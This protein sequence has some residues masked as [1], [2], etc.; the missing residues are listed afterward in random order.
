[1]AWVRWVGQREFDIG[2]SGV[3]SM[4]SKF[5]LTVVWHALI[6]IMLDVSASL[7]WAEGVELNDDQ[8]FTRLTAPLEGEAGRHPDFS[9]RAEVIIERF[10]QLWTDEEF[11]VLLHELSDDTLMLRLRAAETA[12]FSGQEPWMLERARTALEV[13]L[14]RDLATSAHIRRLFDAY[15]AA[16]DF[17]AARMLSESHPDAG[18]PELPEIVPLPEDQGD[19]H[20]IVWHVHDD[21]PRLKGEAINL[22]DIRLLV[23]TSPGCG[24]SHQAAHALGQD[25]II[26]PLM[27]AHALWITARTKSHSFH[28]LLEWN[29]R[30]PGL[31]TVVVD[32]QE[33]WPVSSFHVYPRFFF[34]TG[35]QVEESQG[36]RGGA[37]GLQSIA[38]QFIRLGLLDAGNLTDDAF[39]YADD[40]AASGSCAERAPALAQANEGA[41]IKTSDELDTHLAKLEAGLDSP[42]GKLSEEARRRLVHSISWTSRG[43]AGFRHDDLAALPEPEGFYQIVSLFGKQYFYAGSFYPVELLTDEEADLRDR[44]NCAGDYVP[45]FQSEKDL[46]DQ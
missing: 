11:G 37:E 43:V 17:G 27:R 41:L 9:E 19:P 30:Y 6:L 23:V 14:A 42:F 46:T 35:D 31:E 20:W 29:Q 10:R 36:W 34:M 16:W 3:F 44:I 5:N 15:Q 24:F 12:L 2:A 13:A 1:V 39:A 32:D 33:Q 28:R 8:R 45:D 25:E 18:L 21:P 26:G 7:V 38:D 4:F 40:W 22:D